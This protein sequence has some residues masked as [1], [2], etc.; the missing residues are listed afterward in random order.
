MAKEGPSA[1]H[2]Q[3]IKEY[4]LKKYKDAQK[5]NGYWLNSIDEYLYTGIDPV[6]DYEQIINSITPKDVQQ[7]ANELLKQKNQITVSMISPEKK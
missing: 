2:M 6:K 7:F 4:M 5:E 3:K 1:E